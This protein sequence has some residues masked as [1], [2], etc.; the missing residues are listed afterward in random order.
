VIHVLT[1]Q[2]AGYH[3][4][5]DNG[6]IGP[7]ARLP[8]IPRWTDARLGRGIHVA[9][10]RRSSHRAQLGQDRGVSLWHQK[11]FPSLSFKS[12]INRFSFTYD[13]SLKKVFF[14]LVIDFCIQREKV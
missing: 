11:V 13:F 9:G 12:N 3:R 10:H 7:L 6:S 14:Y 8:R 2:S 1:L 4:Q 5:R